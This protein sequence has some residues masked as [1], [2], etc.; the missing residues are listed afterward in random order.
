VNLLLSPESTVAMSK[1]GG[2]APDGR[3][4]AFDGRAN[5]Y[6]RG[7]GAGL[8]VLK[9]LSK[10][11]RDGDAIY[12]V[13]RGEGINNDGF[14]NG[15]TAPNPQAQEA[16]LRMAY[17]RAAVAPADVDY[18][19]THGTGT[20][21][22]DPIEAG[23]IGRVL[24]T[25]REPSRPLAIGSVKTNI[26]HLEAAAG[27]AGL[28]KVA[29]ALRHG[30][31]PGQLH[32]ESP[33]PN[34]DF[35]GLNLAVQSRTTPWPAADRPATAGVSSFGFG[36]TNCH[37][38]LQ[39]RPRSAAEVLVLSADEAGA[40]RASADAF[41][42]HL[43]SI[44][45]D[46]PLAP[47]CR[48]AAQPSSDGRHR[49]ALSASSVAAL[50]R[51]LDVL[52]D[53]PADGGETPGVTTGSVL[54]QRRPL[55]WILSAHGGQWAGMGRELFE[56]EPVFRH[57]LLRCARAIQREA[58]W[59]L[60]DEILATESR[61]RLHL[62]DVAQPAIFSIQVA[63]AALW[64]SWGL[65]P[66]GVIGHSMGEVAAAHIAGI[67]TLDDAV[68]VIGHRSRLLARTSGKGALAVVGLSASATEE[69]LKNRG[70]RLY[71][72]AF[73]SPLSTLVSGDPAELDALIA[74]LER[75][76]VFCRKVRVDVA[77]HSPQMD[78]LKEELAAALAGI[79][80]EPEQVAMYST[81]EGA[82]LGG[83][84][85]NASY[86]VRNLRQ[87]VLFAQAV[88]KVLASGPATFLE[89]GPHPVLAPAVQQ[90]VERHGPGGRVLESLRRG[91]DERAALLDAA[92]ALY[93]DGYAVR[94]PRVLS[95][96]AAV[97]LP[98][99][100]TASAP[101]ADDGDEPAQPFVLS[102]HTPG[103]L[104]ARAKRFAEW[105][106]S[107]SCAR[108]SDICYTAAVRRAPQ[109]HRFAVAARSESELASLLEAF[110]GGELPPAASIGEREI[111]GP[112]RIAFVFPGQGSQW[113][114]MGRQLLR[115]QPGFRD[116]LMRCDEAIRRL[117]G[118]S[119]AETLAAAPGAPALDTIDVIQPALFSIQ[120]A[121][122][123][124]WRS[125]GVEPSAVVGH[126]MGEVAA[127]HVAGAL[128]L[129][130]AAM[131]ICRRSRLLRR[132]SG[133][134]A[135]A[136][137]ELSIDDAARA[138]Q[139]Y[140]DRLSVAVS[141]SAT[142]TVLSGDPDALEQ[143][144][145]KLTAAGVFCKHVKVDVASHSP[146]VDPLQADLLRALESV[147]P[148]R[149]R[150]PICST[151]TAAAT[152]GGEFDATY[153]ARNLREPVLF[154]R[155]V[156]R[157]IEDGF[158]TFIEVSA[159]PLLLPAVQESL[160]TATRPGIAVS[161]LR[162]EEDERLAIL[163]SV[164][165][166]F[167]WGHD[168]DFDLLF[169]SGGAV[170]SLPPAEWDRQR[171]WLDAAERTPVRAA[172]GAAMYEVEWTR[173]ERVAAAAAA[174]RWLVLADGRGLA[175]GVVTRLGAAGD[176]AELIPAG[177]GLPADA[178]A[179]DAIVDVRGL[180]G[181]AESITW[182]ALSL[183]Q[184]LEATAAGHRPRLYFVT[185]QA[186]P[187]AGSSVKAPQQAALWG[188]ASA[189]AVEYP[190]YSC[191]RIDVDDDGDAGADRVAEELRAWSADDLVALR[192]NE[193]Y[194]ARLK[195]GVAA[196]EAAAALR[197]LA[198]LCESHG[199]AIEPLL[200]K[201]LPSPGSRIVAP[202]LPD[203]S[204]GT[205]LITGG[206]GGLGIVTAEWL[207]DRGARSI[208]LMGR[209]DPSSAALEAI[210]R[211]RQ[212]GATITVMS[213]DVASEPDLRRVFGA[214]DSSLP[215]LRVVIH[216]AGMLDDGVV[217]T[218]DRDKVRNVFAPKVR[219]ALLL[220]ELTRERDLDLFVLY[221]S[222][223]SFLGAAGQANH[224]AANALLDALAH[225]RRAAGLP[226]SS[227]NWGVWSE[228]GSAAA[229]SGGGGRLATAGLVSISPAEGVAALEQLLS[230]DAAQ[231]AVMH[232]DAA[233]WKDAH[234]GLARSTL[235]AR[236]AERGV[237]ETSPAAPAEP[238]L[239]DRLQAAPAGSER[240]NVMEAFL[241][242]AVAKV[243]RMPLARIELDKPVRAMGLDSLMA[244][245]FRN[246]VEAAAGISIPTTL[247][248]N[249]PTIAK[250]APEIATRMG[251]ELDSSI[252]ENPVAAPA[253]TVAEAPDDDLEALLNEV[254]T[255]S[256]DDVRRALAQGTQRVADV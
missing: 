92:G 87:P 194:V 25:V 65:E 32:F 85:F 217:T 203:F 185:C 134:G 212:H 137:V 251:V 230:A 222:A 86:W 14:S 114:G 187:A 157:L 5:G 52:L 152:D 103:T 214:I 229:K 48:A 72:V 49:A 162:R 111:A 246:K 174:R 253:S 79:R 51:Q 169:P 155:A 184:A 164:G 205:A 125:W 88:E 252:D 4:K 234:P 82:R 35:A 165:A 104:T 17:A 6:V 12:C 186:Q 61:S 248:W 1:F 16:M 3:S 75:E 210:E 15:L 57:T 19:E 84:R 232:F 71:V 108:F 135:M 225:H 99:D 159:H 220:H 73:N 38:V 28:I 24:G 136:V 18:I 97:D 141:N 117:E 81:V 247:V 64:R 90:S 202:A 74:E 34:I 80:P 26:G 208:V 94:W 126:S 173:E 30:V 101:G 39:S 221:S 93:V 27:I 209:R 166:L 161:S 89:L 118:W 171:C 191:T 145:A 70:D 98:G 149:A 240:R 223:M 201:A 109:A 133:Q 131:V 45:D 154:S 142:S 249:Y 148:G 245:E 158:D 107:G 144:M 242:R 119:I 123:A 7:E 106:R 256:D 218:L 139:G 120:V 20:F 37:I 181:D 227:I 116:A 128:S 178:T 76:G 156:S 241:S 66:D 196:L 41:R 13:V 83:R 121:L 206:L 176:R 68:K 140:E 153:W 167:T 124:L 146:Q 21:L 59:D 29:L 69:A 10:A 211:L 168:L 189:I 129:E 147:A 163:S 216:S 91:E 213:G 238:A 180:D 207:V 224:A 150:L 239:A 56:R 2:M 204:R 175:A 130:D 182:N 183:V 179:S 100:L 250:L 33:N 197:S 113:I 237:S 115:T 55:I 42:R 67:L 233:A 160:R 200:R 22:G 96:S 63:L 198:S 122:A 188:L 231:A 127:S 193:R 138:L 50:R 9:P 143:V 60:I 110:A 62:M 112:G 236:L 235:F 177:D 36:G 77:A 190:D 228:I 23:A 226:A 199:A 170:V 54:A 195:E 215:P 44:G 78:P 192:G 46:A 102:S 40:L 219:G 58:G 8:V 11:L 172:T 95:P 243:L 43:R 244:V 105:I 53:R 254:E 47:I 31:I 151:V 132:I 255:L